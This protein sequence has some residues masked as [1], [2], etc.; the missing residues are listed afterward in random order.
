MVR[1]KYNRGK[2]L[3]QT[4]REHPEILFSDIYMD[5]AVELDGKAK[6]VVKGYPTVFMSDGLWNVT[7]SE[8]L[9]RHLQKMQYLGTDETAPFFEVT[10][11]HLNLRGLSL[12]D[13]MKEWGRLEGEG[14]GKIYGAKE[15]FMLARPVEAARFL[16]SMLRLKEATVQDIELYNQGVETFN[17]NLLP[18]EEDLKKDK[19]AVDPTGDGIKVSESSLNE[20][21][22]KI[23][24][25]LNDLKIHSLAW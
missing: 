17:N 15:F 6:R 10:K 23:T 18:S 9:D 3:D 11:G 12:I 24:N 2:T 8:L 7:T 20:V 13:F 4:M 19:I 14:G 1:Q 22:A 25:M 21:K 16:Y 5:G